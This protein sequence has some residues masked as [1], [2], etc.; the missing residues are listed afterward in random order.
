[1]KL[2]DDFC[3]LAFR[4]S[5][6]VIHSPTLD[7]PPFWTILLMAG[8]RSLELENFFRLNSVTGSSLDQKLNVD[9]LYQRDL[10]VYMYVLVRW[11]HTKLHISM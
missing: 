11:V 2:C 3:S 6:R 8:F 4:V 5:F 7:R 10:P 1:M 9:T